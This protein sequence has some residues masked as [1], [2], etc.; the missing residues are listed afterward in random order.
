MQFRR[1]ETEQ[2]GMR[3]Y[4]LSASLHLSPDPLRGEPAIGSN[5]VVTPD[6]P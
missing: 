5:P 3:G 2:P 1:L 4:D 6:L